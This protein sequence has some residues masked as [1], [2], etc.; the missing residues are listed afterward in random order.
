M[1]I[2]FTF[3]NQLNIYAQTIKTASNIVNFF[4]SF[5]T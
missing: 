3:A 4:Y 2:F 5:S 1:L